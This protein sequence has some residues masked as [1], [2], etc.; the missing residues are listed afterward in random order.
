MTDH[1]LPKPPQADDL[2]TLVEQMKL[3]LMSRATGGSMEEPE[4]R[5]IRKILLSVPQFQ[6]RLP[7]FLKSCQHTSDFWN[8]IREKFETYAERRKFLADE[9]NPLLEVLET[10]E[11]SI[12]PH[13]ERQNRIG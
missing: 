9:F 12:E 8:F 6:G 3:G 1:W 11:T 10:G 4:Y 2:A 7:S 13:Y 5:R